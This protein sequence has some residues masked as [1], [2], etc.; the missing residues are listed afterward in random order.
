[1]YGARKDGAM[2]KKKNDKTPMSGAMM[3]KNEKTP[4]NGA[5]YEK[6]TQDADDAAGKMARSGAATKNERMSMRTWR[7]DNE[8]QQ[9][10]STRPWKNYWEMK[11]T[12]NGRNAEA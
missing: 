8:R 10:W 4:M 9:K 11:K 5:M 2:M 6:K 12:P 3:K 1:M 7:G